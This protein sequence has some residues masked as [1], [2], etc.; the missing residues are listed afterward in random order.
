L[1]DDADEYQTVVDA[2]GGGGGDGCLSDLFDW[3][4]HGE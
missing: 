4:E 2:N 3:K 1:T